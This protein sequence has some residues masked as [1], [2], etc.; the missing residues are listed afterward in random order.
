MK[1]VKRLLL[2]LLVVF[3]VL[4]SVPLQGFTEFDWTL[5][6]FGK[7][8]G[9]EAEAATEYT[10]G[11]YTYTV[12]NSKATITSFNK[13]VSGNITIPSTLGGY[14]VIGIG[15]SA[16]ESCESL[17][18][19]TIP[20]SVKYIEDFSFGYCINL[21]KITIPNSVTSIG[22]CAFDG[23]AYYNNENNWIDDVLYIGNHLIEA[24]AAIVGKYVIKS[25]TV[26][27]ADSAFSKCESLTGVTIPSSV[28][29]IGDH[30]FNLCE[31]L[32]S[33]IIPNGTKSIGNY[34]FK[35]CES[36][37]SITISD[38]VATIGEGAFQGCGLKSIT[39]PNS[40]TNIERYLF[41]GCSKLTTVKI[42]N[43]VKNIKDSTFS[44][45]V[46][47]TSIKLPSSLT[48]IGK[49][50]F[51]CCESLKSITIPNGTK[52][53][54]NY[55]FRACKSLA[56]I[57]ISDSVATIGES[58]F[59]ECESLKS[60]TIPNS[61]TSIEGFTFY[62]CSNLESVTIPNS[63]TNIG[64]YVFSGCQKLTTVTIPNSV[65]NITGWTFQS[66]GLTS[67]TIPDSV[68]II[69]QS[70]FRYCENLR[71]VT[72]SDSIKNISHA[73][74]EGCSSITDVYYSG[75]ETQ[76]NNI[77]I[78][79]N[80]E[81][82]TN[83]TIHYNS[84]SSS[85]NYTLTYNA[86]GGT[87][88]PKSATV[89]SGT[90]VVL[91]KPTKSFK[92]TYNANGGSLSSSS[93]TVSC[94]FKNWNTNS[95][96]T[97]TAYSSGANFTVNSNRTLYA[98]WTNP[99]IGTLPTPT[100]SGYTFTGWF[101]SGGKEVTSS[102]TVSGNGTIYAQ[103]SKGSDTVIPT[104]SIASTNNVANKQ[105]VTLKMSDN[106]KV[107]GYY[108]GTSSTYTSN[109]YTSS[110]S[111]SVT[112]TVS[113]AGTYYLVVK[114]SSGNV[115]DRKSITFYK[116]TLNA[117]GGSVSPTAVL[118]ASGKSFTFPTP[119]R[120][121]YTYNGWSTSSTATSCV[122]TLKPTANR[123][124]YACWKGSDI[125][126]LGE[127]TYS[128]ENYGDS[129]N[130][131][132]CFGMSMTSSAYHLDILN[133]TSV[134]GNKTSD[135]Y[136]LKN[137]ATVRKPICRY[138]DIQG[139]P[140]SYATVAGGSYYKN[141]V[142]NVTSD[143]NAVINYVKSHAFD[144]KGLFQVALRK[145]TGGHA[146]NFLRYQ[147]VNG[148]ERIYIYDNNFP[149][150][151]TY[152][153]KNSSGKIYQAPYSTF[154]GALDCIALRSVE[155]YFQYAKNYDT[156]KCIYA[157][158]DTM[159]IYGAKVYEMECGEGV[160]RVVFELPEDEDSVTIVPLDESVNFEYMNEEYSL[161]KVEEDTVGTLT[162]LSEEVN[163]EEAAKPSLKTF[164]HSKCTD[165]DK[166][167]ICDTC[168]KILSIGNPSK[169]VASQSENSVK[170][171]WSEIENVTGYRIFQS[172]NGKWVKAATVTGTTATI[173]NLKAGTKYTFAVRAYVN[174]YGDI[175]WSNSYT[176]IGTATKAVKP[177]KLTTTQTTS[178][179]KLTWS[180][181]AGATGYRVYYRTSTKNSWSTL[182]KAMSGTSYTVKNL[183]SGKAYQFAVKPY[184][185]SS[186]GV[187]WSDYRAVFAATLPA[188]PV[189][190]VVS[191]SKGRLTVSWSA[192]SGA[193]G[194]QVYYKVGSGS[195][196]LYKT[197]ND[198]MILN[199][200]LNSGYKYTFAVRAYKTVAGTTYRSGYKAVS[201]TV[202]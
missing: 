54:G 72:I 88:S 13:S 173:K 195:Y 121:G 90:K 59:Y 3:T 200:A 19:I 179:I 20:N 115:S 85:T 112:K 15:E 98:Q 38:S 117:N 93:K 17:K 58:A 40:V 50:A 96:G 123:T 199:F 101:T 81:D 182:V 142:N 46:S 180:K 167:G 86:N 163:D 130:D 139:Y 129:K 124:Y 37:A 89:E 97:G 7:W 95:A 118:T 170:L 1:T 23:T 68:T 4:T 39:I 14:K 189:T 67:V 132:H 106:V 190:K 8:F 79:S 12:S 158:K 174:E 131:G 176:T 104:G 10:S 196:K 145:G 56:S 147:V 26:T 116:T 27:I 84:N 28:T 153:Y 159:M 102:T 150:V 133:I 192:V 110:S 137:N 165:K 43:S 202:K 109:T 36:L 2:G 114:D 194:Y 186:A 160:S 34:A 62:G 64:L 35:S 152:L 78:G 125:Y 161:T 197:Y 184:I 65:K 166:D 134:G 144:N 80:N 128:F 91:P 53:I 149:T 162:L 47:L 42:P 154:S 168:N 66:C 120:S 156:S 63:V 73:A 77:S 181:S 32:K 74:F 193:T 201:V 82:L 191:P 126:N 183:P 31:S 22:Y 99:K 107:S 44:Y 60:I 29:Y 41:F 49:Y 21:A 94:T 33:I 71:S 119:K 100:R 148:Q 136:A 188:N 171:T 138:Q 52:S 146:V 70:T 135:V 185:S 155:I 48:N 5:F 111:A 25:G 140:R 24:E 175:T 9:V 103:W 164:S 11:Y 177:A 127:E 18:S 30:A 83:A 157:D 61:V 45:C 55:A 92:I 16:F 169:I 187:V 76:W 141:N 57:T 105:T 143:W 69:N 198:P 75:T 51:D 172:V 113:S 151:E 122:K 87:V 108:W 6:D 178:A